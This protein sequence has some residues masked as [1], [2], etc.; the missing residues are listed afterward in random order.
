MSTRSGRAV[1]GRVPEALAAD[2]AP[3]ASTRAAPASQSLPGD[4]L[5]VGRVVG[6]WGVKGWLRVQPFS[7]DAEALLA[8]PRWFVMPP[9]G[10]GGLP[11]GPTAERFPPSLVITQVRP[12][13]EGL[14]ALPEGV[15]DRAAAE[16]L[17]GARLFVS[18]SSFPAAGRDEYY[19]VDL[20][21]L[22]VRNRQG[23]LLGEVSGLL[24]TGPHS[25]LRVT[26]PSAP[27]DLPPSAA[28]EILI[29]FV[30]AYVDDVDL[31]QRCITVD[32]GLDY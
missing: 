29:P 11:K 2:T 6:A 31:S 20:I 12:H 16:A 21:G 7:D 10:A 30:G 26:P 9:E 19:W 32:W 17:R 5:E 4:A 22:Q 25:V 1:V 24:D 18:R 14:V 8:S 28:D 27:G 3:P 13:G 15:Q 23:D